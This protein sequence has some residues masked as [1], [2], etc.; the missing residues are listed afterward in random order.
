M[1][2]VKE[3]VHHQVFGINDKIESKTRL[4]IPNQ[5]EN[6][7]SCCLSYTFFFGVETQCEYPQHKYL[8][9]SK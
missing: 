9:T 7:S 3:Q 5:T 8:F 1:H 2:L 4:I 6:Y